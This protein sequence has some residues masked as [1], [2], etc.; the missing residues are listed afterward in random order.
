MKAIKL[1]ITDELA[2]AFEHLHPSYGEKSR[3]FR[4][5]LEAYVRE[6]MKRPKDNIY[7]RVMEQRR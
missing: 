7:E 2:E 4:E 1:R 3:V 5:L 6:A